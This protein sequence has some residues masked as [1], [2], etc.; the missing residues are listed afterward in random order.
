MNIISIHISLRKNHF[1]LKSSHALKKPHFPNNIY[2]TINTIQ[3]QGITSN[4]L[5]QIR[6][7]INPIY[8]NMNIKYVQ[9][10]LQL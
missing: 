9:D 2:H 3:W 7:F 8:M 4:M 1:F 10:L 5:T 6:Y